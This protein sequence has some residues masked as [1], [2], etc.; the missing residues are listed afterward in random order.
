MA[1]EEEGYRTPQSWLNAVCAVSLVCALTVCAFNGFLGG[2][3]AYGLCIVT[4]VALCRV[5]RP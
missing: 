2:A 4:G 3:L 1:E 5:I